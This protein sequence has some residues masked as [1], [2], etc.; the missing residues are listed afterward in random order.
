MISGEKTPPDT[1]TKAIVPEWVTGVLIL[2]GV[3]TLS[4]Y[5][6]AWVLGVPMYM[7]MYARPWKSLQVFLLG[8]VF[9]IPVGWAFMTLLSVIDAIVVMLSGAYY[10]TKQ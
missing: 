6:S 10:K 4:T 9:L 8:A 1:T 5:A 3:P 2:L 7:S